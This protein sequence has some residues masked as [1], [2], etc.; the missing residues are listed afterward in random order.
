MAWGAALVFFP[1]A[2]DDESPVIEPRGLV[3]LADAVVRP[4]PSPAPSSTPAASSAPAAAMI[5]KA[6]PTPAPVARDA[7]GVRVPRTPGGESS[8]GSTTQ[9][10]QGV[11]DEPSTTDDPCA[12]EDTEA[13][14]KQCE[15]ELDGRQ[16]SD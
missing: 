12:D 13:E 4:T 7:N 1:T 14:Q 6:A 15:D 3:D 10:V 8:G 16:H 11:H 9:V 5:A 2:S